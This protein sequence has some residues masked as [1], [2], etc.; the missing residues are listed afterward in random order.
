[1]GPGR[2]PTF[3]GWAR[4]SSPTGSSFPRQRVPTALKETLLAVSGRNCGSWSLWRPPLLPL[5][6]TQVRG[7]QRWN[8]PQRWAREASGEHFLSEGRTGE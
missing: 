8:S 3:R 2:A 4:A 6:L 1:M 5:G 7:L